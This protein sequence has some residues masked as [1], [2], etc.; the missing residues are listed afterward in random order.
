MFHGDVSVVVLRKPVGAVG[1][2]GTEFDELHGVVLQHVGGDGDLLGGGV[3][4]YPD[5]VGCQIAGREAVGAW[6]Q[7]AFLLA[8][9]V[10]VVPRDVR[11]LHFGV[12]VT[13][14]ADDLRLCGL[15]VDVVERGLEQEVVEAVAPHHQS[16][17]L[18]LG[19]LHHLVVE[20]E[21]A[22]VFGD[23]GRALAAD[24]GVHLVDVVAQQG[25]GLS[26]VDQGDAVVIVV[27]GASLLEAVR[28]ENVGRAAQIVVVPCKGIDVGQ[29]VAG[30]H[31]NGFSAPRHFAAYGLCAV[32]FVVVRL[33]VF[34][35]DVARRHVVGCGFA[36]L[37]GG[38][39]V[40]VGAGY[41]LGAGALVSDLRAVGANFQ[42]QVVE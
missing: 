23:A 40:I 20:H 13:H 7:R 4:L 33:S 9:V 5:A 17:V 16:L 27:G 21:V 12:A 24:D 1:G 8:A 10:V 37:L 35:N 32:V 42:R 28:Y 31:V 30:L 18:A 2:I 22:E 39:I 38:I 19:P 14:I 6:G 3:Q 15:A 11:E 26:L 29:Y 36:V 41:G 25:V 34:F